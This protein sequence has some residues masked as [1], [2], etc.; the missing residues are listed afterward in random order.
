[1]DGNWDFKL[2]CGR[3]WLSVISLENICFKSFYVQVM[4]ADLELVLQAAPGRRERKERKVCPASQ[5]KMDLKVLLA[6]LVSQV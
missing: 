3:K 4:K 6:R 1:M 2:Q 5:G